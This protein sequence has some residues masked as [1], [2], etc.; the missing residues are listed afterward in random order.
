MPRSFEKSFKRLSGIVK[1][2]IT[3]TT[4][5][6]PAKANTHLQKISG[7]WKKKKNQATY[8]STRKTKLTRPLK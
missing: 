5:T 6:K 4:M 7:E 2:T 1:K 8:P 3:M